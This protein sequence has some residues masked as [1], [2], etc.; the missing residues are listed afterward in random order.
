M[1]DRF[2]NPMADPDTSSDGSP[3]RPSAPPT[4][5]PAPNTALPPAPISVFPAAVMQKVAIRSHVPI[6]LD[7]AAANYT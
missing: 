5:F 1:D 3:S 2:F 6:T 7:L 4:V